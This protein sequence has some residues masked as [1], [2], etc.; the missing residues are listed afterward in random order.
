MLKIECAADVAII[1]NAAIYSHKEQWEK[2]DN[3]ED[4]LIRDKRPYIDEELETAGFSWCANFNYQKGKSLVQ[5][6]VGLNTLSIMASL[7][8]MNVTFNSFNKKKHKKK[9]YLFLED[10]RLRCK[11]EYAIALALAETLEW[12]PDFY[13][14][15]SKIENEC[16]CFGHAAVTRDPFSYLGVAHKVR[17][18][19]Y[20]DRT[21][22]A[23]PE[24]WLTFD[25]IKAE[26]LYRQYLRFK[27]DETTSVTGRDGIS[28]NVYSS[29]GR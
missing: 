13:S 15:V 6:N 8:F 9:I 26:F 18:I 23:N 10:P 24:C 27:T 4:Y 21:T 1:L 29:G 22:F 12:D 5:K 25:I 16:F 2:I 7:A 17:E 28:Y 14:F 20:E 11:F 19:A 3:M